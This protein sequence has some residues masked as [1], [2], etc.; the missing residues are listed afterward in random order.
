MSETYAVRHK[1][2]MDKG[3]KEDPVTMED[4][5]PIAEAGRE[6][7]SY[8]RL[9]NNI[10]VIMVYYHTPSAYT[11]FITNKFLKEPETNLPLNPGFKARIDLYYT[12]LS[13]LSPKQLLL[14]IRRETPELQA[15]DDQVKRDM[16]GRYLRGEGTLVERLILQIS[17]FIDDANV[18]HSYTRAEA[19]ALLETAQIGQWLLRKSSYPDTEL[20]TN[21]AVSMKTS[22]KINH[23][24]ITHIKGYGYTA[25]PKFPT[26][27]QLGLPVRPE[28][29]ETPD[30]IVV[31]TL[32]SQIPIPIGKEVYSCFISA[33]E[34]IFLSSDEFVRAQLI[35]LGV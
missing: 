35:G 11:T 18:V 2:Q 25:S 20:I 19:N 10:P 7:I 13:S 28:L 15:Q 29:N 8:L 31:A 4:L 1:E 22:T 21:R 14:S 27:Q 24:L 12:A 16:F 33:L 17:L 32:G 3:T 9:N 6:T 5:R 30:D 26:R 23:Y 34:S